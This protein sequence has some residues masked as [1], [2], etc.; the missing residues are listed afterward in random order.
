MR[1]LNP[2][3]QLV[4]V[5]TLFL[6]SLGVEAKGLAD[7]GWIEFVDVEKGQIRFEAKIDTGADVSSINARFIRR[8]VRDDE[9]WVQIVLVNNNGKKIVLEKPVI[10][11]A[12]IKRKQAESIE[13]PV[14]RFNICLGNIARRVEVNL[15]KR[16]NF[17]YKMLIGRNYLRGTYLV[18][19]SKEHTTTPGC[20][21]D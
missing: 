14:V 17:K 10:R 7:I 12:R 20:P 8:F 21:Y 16:K 3:R 1:W 4:T 11:Y 9:E 13:R 19:S 15:S 5:A 18:D 6:L 2:Q